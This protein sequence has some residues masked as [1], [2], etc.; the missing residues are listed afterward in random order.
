ML[1]VYAR[2]IPPNLHA[3]GEVLI[4]TCSSVISTLRSP[5]TWPLN[6]HYLP[7]MTQ[8]AS[9]ESSVHA[10][11]HRLTRV[12]RRD[13]LLLAQLLLLLILDRA[14]VITYR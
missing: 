13:V 9:F 8:L 6:F 7:T 1:L 12:S 10:L 14:S 5:K 11:A 3:T 4:R 2:L